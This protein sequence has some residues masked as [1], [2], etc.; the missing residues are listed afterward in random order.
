MAPLYQWLGQMSSGLFAAEGVLG[1]AGRIGLELNQ[2]IQY[3]IYSEGIFWNILV[4]LKEKKNQTKKP[5]TLKYISEV[6]RTKN[7]EQK[8]PVRRRCYMGIVRKCYSPV[9]SY[10]KAGKATQ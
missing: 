4:L 10:R 8:P 5:Q 9:T 3:L 7:P 1:A 2:N 6:Q